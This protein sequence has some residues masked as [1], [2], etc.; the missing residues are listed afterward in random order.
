MEVGSRV[1]FAIH[2]KWL[3]IQKTSSCK[4]CIDSSSSRRQFL[5]SADKENSWILGMFIDCVNLLQML[6]DFRT[7]HP[8][9]PNARPTLKLQNIRL[10]TCFGIGSPR[11]TM[12]RYAQLEKFETMADS[13][14]YA[15]H[16]GFEEEKLNELVRLC[17]NPTNAS[18][19]DGF[20]LELGDV[21]DVVN[22][23]Q[24]LRDDLMRDFHFVDGRK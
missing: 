8:R 4:H 12:F 7:E 19:L 14:N 17:S 20:G 22:Q 23:L 21:K 10:V 2:S 24:Q 15:F 5:L 9:V 6:L 13:K 3:L 1:Y 11:P 16:S 18:F